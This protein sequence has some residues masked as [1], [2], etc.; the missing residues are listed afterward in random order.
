VTTAEIY[1]TAAYLVFLTIVLLYVV[2]YSFKVARLEHE[3]AELT[4]RSA[5]ALDDGESREQNQALVV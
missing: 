5:A 4:Q 2:I 3:V 1:V